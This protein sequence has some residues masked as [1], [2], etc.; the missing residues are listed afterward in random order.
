MPRSVLVSEMM[1]SAREH[2]ND[3]TGKLASDSVLIG[4]LN[5]AY[6]LYYQ[7]L[8]EADP[9]FYQTETTF[10]TV[11]GTKAYS[12]PLDWI[13]TIQ[14]GRF[15]G[16]RYSKLDRLNVDEVFDYGVNG[17]PTKY[18]PEGG[19]LAL[20]ATPD[21]VYTIKH[22]YIPTWTKLTS[23]A[24][25]IDGLLG[26]EELI[27]LEAAIRLRHKDEIDDS[28]LVA[29]R[30]MALLRLKQQAFQRTVVDAQVAGEKFID[31]GP[32]YGVRDRDYLFW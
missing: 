26:N 7:T 27:E 1:T 5:Q 20:Y 12:L 6:G 25:E 30:D 21:G 3:P 15:N 31:E 16:S 23:G 18:Q 19:Q 11:A 24:Q 9:A 29:R 10:S 8:V 32:G 2:A 28:D 22:I 13:S 14:V 17:C 4:Y